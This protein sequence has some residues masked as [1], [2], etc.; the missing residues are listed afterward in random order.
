MKAWRIHEP[1]SLTLDEL[2]VQSVGEGCVKIKTLAAGI[3][4]TDA[5]M[6]D[7]SL[8]VPAAPMIIGRSCVGLVVET[9]EGVLGLQRGD[10]VAVDPFV[11]CK[12][13]PACKAGKPDRCE[14]LTCMGVDDNGFM[15][16]FSVV[17]ADA[18]HPLPERIKDTDATFLGHIALA[19][20][21]IDKLNLDKGENI[22][23]VGANAFGLIL[24]QVAL[25]YQAVPIMVD[26]DAERLKIAEA[27]G[28]YYTINSVE[29]DPQ[30]RIFSITG[31]RM[32]E[33]V[34]YVA[35]SNMSFFRSLGFAAKSG[36]VAVLGWEDNAAEQQSDFSAILT[37]QLH[38]VGVN[39]GAKQISAA[40]NLLANRTLDVSKIISREIPFSGVGECVRELAQDKDR[41]IMTVVKF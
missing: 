18:A 11:S 14:K 34:A 6:Y 20:N 16:D 41:Y 23:I 9:G 25:Y 30:K 2:P 7:G 3:S 4:L 27:L 39:N 28:V 29:A 10:R 22:V 8:P 19:I 33:T 40:I 15:S 13:C 31:G 1:G 35:T 5:D 32:S 36:R 12:S 24:A 26:I 17:S 37:K 38:I 21:T